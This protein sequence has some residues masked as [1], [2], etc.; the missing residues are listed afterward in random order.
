MAEEECQDMTSDSSHNISSSTSSTNSSGACIVGVCV[1]C[2][3]MPTGSK[4]GHEHEHVY[5]CLHSKHTVAMPGL[6]SRETS[7]YIAVRASKQPW[8]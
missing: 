6:N 4:E 5:G 2:L 1:L 3:E 7:S 8:T